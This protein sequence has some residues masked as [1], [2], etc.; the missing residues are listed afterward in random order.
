MFENIISML[1][2]AANAENNNIKKELEKLNKKVNNLNEVKNQSEV[3]VKKDIYEY[4]QRSL[5]SL[6]E[7]KRHIE[8]KSLYV[9]QASAVLVTLFTTLFGIINT[10]INYSVYMIVG[11]VMFYILILIAILCLLIALDDTIARWF[12]PKNEKDNFT[13]LNP[14][15]VDD[16]ITALKENYDL[17]RYYTLMSKA[18]KKSI[19]SGDIINKVKVK[20]FHIGVRVFITS[21]VVVIFLGILVA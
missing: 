10:K 6:F 17:T 19:K 14:P 21:V 4:S 15:Q 11:I 2:K 16:I 8:I 7:R 9:L 5:D 13:F 12:K 18:I 1:K 3:E 20:Y